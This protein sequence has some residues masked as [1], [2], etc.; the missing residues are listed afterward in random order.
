MDFT[1]RTIPTE[2]SGAE[3]RV[4][5]DP[6][7]GEASLLSTQPYALSVTTLEPCKL[8]VL[9]RPKFARLM[10]LMPDLREAIRSYNMLK[11]KLISAK[12]SANEKATSPDG[13]FRH[14]DHRRCAH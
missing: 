14:D 11:R 6:I 3:L 13:S 9:Q 4:G 2:L 12:L 8:L 5:E 1:E 10:R 7:F